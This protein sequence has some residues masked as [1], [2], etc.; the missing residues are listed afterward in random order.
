MQVKCSVCWDDFPAPSEAADAAPPA[1]LSAACGHNF[2]RSCWQGYITASLENARQ[3][4][5]MRCPQFPRCW[6][7]VPRTLV[8]TVATPAQT[9]K[10]DALQQTLIVDENPRVSWCSQ[11][12]CK[13]V[14][15]SLIHI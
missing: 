8:A 5:D 1:V 13:V 4:T 6:A 15:L 10:L 9:A 14:A 7:S 2:C 12:G 3:A 11:P